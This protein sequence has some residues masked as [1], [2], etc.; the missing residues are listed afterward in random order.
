MRFVRFPGLSVAKLP[1]PVHCLFSLAKDEPFQPSGKFVIYSGAVGVS[2]AALGLCLVLRPLVDTIL[3]G[4]MITIVAVV[5]YSHLP[6]PQT[7]RP[8]LGER[9]GMS[10]I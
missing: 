10:D 2:L 7:I 9:Y 3:L 8:I 6:S 1:S 5:V 4:I